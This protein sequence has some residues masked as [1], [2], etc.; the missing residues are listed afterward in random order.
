MNNHVVSGNAQCKYSTA[1]PPVAYFV[2]LVRTASIVLVGPHEQLR[3]S[4]Y[5]LNR[6]AAL[7]PD[8]PRVAI[9]QR[10]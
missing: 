3:H 5:H 9:G 4:E 10:H 2:I 8:L 7:V 6:A 1:L